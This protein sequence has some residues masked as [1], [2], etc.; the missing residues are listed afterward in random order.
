MAVALLPLWPNAPRM[1]V[2]SHHGYLWANDAWQNDAT[3][4]RL[5]QTSTNVTQQDP[6]SYE[7]TTVVL[8]TK[9]MDVDRAYWL[10]YR[11]LRTAAIKRK[12]GSVVFYRIPR[13][14]LWLTDKLGI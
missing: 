12:D 6:V 8:D 9:M 3:L 13:W 14:F 10:I 11:N 5:Q 4:P 2:L 1:W 7:G